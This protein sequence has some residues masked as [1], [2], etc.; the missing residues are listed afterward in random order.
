M[1]FH[2]SLAL[3]LIPTLVL[4]TGTSFQMQSPDGEVSFRA[5]GHPSAL[6]VI[7]KGKGPTGELYLNGTVLK[8]R[9]E[10]DLRTLGTGFELRDQHMTEKYLEV[11]NYP[12]SNLDLDEIKLSS[13]LDAPGT[14]QRQ[15]A[16]SGALHF[17]GKN[18][19][20]SGIADLKRLSSGELDLDSKFSLKLSDYGISIP[21]W[22]GIT[23]ADE[24][25]IQVVSKAK[26]G[27]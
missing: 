20:I 26:A 25:E 9:I 27:K 15:V 11:G 16:F 18:G 8:G 12:K 2:L 4:A 19:K 22:A 1:R 23:I 7:G 3:S 6:K 24:V 17:H 13:P 5:I 14:E 21:K 10:A